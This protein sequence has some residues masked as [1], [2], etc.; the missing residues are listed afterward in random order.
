MTS[1]SKRN[2]VTWA[3]RNGKLNYLKEKVLDEIENDISSVMKS[4]AISG[5]GLQVH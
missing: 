4:R 1:F 5:Y 3:E 2:T